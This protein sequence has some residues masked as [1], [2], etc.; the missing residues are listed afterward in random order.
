MNIDN[1]LKNPPKFLSDS[2]GNPSSWQL[3]DEV[4][5]FINENISS[6]SRTLETR[7]GISTILFTI[8]QSDHTCIVPDPYQ[9]KKIKEF[10]DQ[11]L[12]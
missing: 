7:A 3:G 2:S 4:L 10:C 9:I 12:I 8:R 6:T 5:Y 1:L 11:N